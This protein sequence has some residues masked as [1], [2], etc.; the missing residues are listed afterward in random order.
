VEAL[1]FLRDKRVIFVLLLD[2]IYEINVR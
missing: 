1:S 2:S